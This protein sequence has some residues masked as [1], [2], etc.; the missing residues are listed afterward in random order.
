[1][2]MTSIALR[3]CSAAA[4]ASLMK[5]SARWTNS[6]QTRS[7]ASRGS[8][9]WPLSR[10]TREEEGS[11]VSASAQLPR[12]MEFKRSFMRPS[13]DSRS[14]RESDGCEEVRVQRMMRSS[15]P[16]MAM[17]S[18]LVVDMLWLGNG[19]NFQVPATFLL[20]P[21]RGLG[22]WNF[23]YIFCQFCYFIKKEPQAS[24]ESVL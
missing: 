24:V 7:A 12:S 2:H 18:C 11:E 23:L 8:E 20:T 17:A 3:R 4:A 1:M 21:V 19:S 5:D 13:N 6:E 16:R 22:F 10:K 14:W 15:Q 9:S